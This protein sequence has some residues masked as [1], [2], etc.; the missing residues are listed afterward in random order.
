MRI[1]IS[2]GEEDRLQIRLKVEYI[3][4]ERWLRGWFI[5]EMIGSEFKKKTVQLTARS[6]EKAYCLKLATLAEEAKSSQ[7]KESDR[8]RLGDNG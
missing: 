2:L 6:F 7:S 3:H 5:P 4:S 8:G 1:L